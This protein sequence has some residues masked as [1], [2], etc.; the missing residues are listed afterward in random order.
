MTP[1][2]PLTENQKVYLR[3]GLRELC[4]VFWGPNDK[5]CEEAFQGAFL[6]VFDDPAWPLDRQASEVLEQIS[7]FA[8]TFEKPAALCRT[9]EEE[10][11]RLF[12]NHHSGVPAPL[13]HSCYTSGDRR[14]MGEPARMMKA[15]LAEQGLDLAA[16]VHEPA[17]HLS[18]ELEYLYYLLDKGWQTNERR[19]IE[20]ARRF[21]SA[22]MLPWVQ[23]FFHRLEGEAGTPFYPCA[24]ALLIMLLRGIADLPWKA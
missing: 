13:F 19:M 18:I 20:E 12:I 15:L 5:W 24:T 8:A 9:L 17:D 10:Y 21:A 14:L 4:A 2:A 16:S 3:N 11:V 1:L 22:A 23:V 7:A 6:K